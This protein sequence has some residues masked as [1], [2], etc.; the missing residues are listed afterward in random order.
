MR[1]Y[2]SLERAYKTLQLNLTNNESSTVSVVLF[3]A[4]TD[5]QITTSSATETSTVGVGST[6]SALAFNPSN[7]SVYVANTGDD[8]VSVIDADGNVTTI[9][10]GIGDAPRGVAFNSNDGNIWVSFGTDNEV[11]VIDSATN[12]V[13][14]TISVGTSPFELVYSPANQSMYVSINGDDEVAI[15][16]SSD[17]VT[18]VNVGDQPRGIAYNTANQEVY[19][20]NQADNNVTRID[21]DGNTT[22]I[23]VGTTPQGIAYNEINR[24]MYVANTLFTVNLI[25][26][27][28]LDDS[29]TTITS[30]GLQPTGVAYSKSNT[31]IYVTNNGSADVTVIDIADNIIQTV[32]VGNNPDAATYNSNDESIYVA[33]IVDSTVSIL[34]SSVTVE[35]SLGGTGLDYSN[36]IEQIR[37]CPLYVKGAK[38]LPSSDAQFN[39]DINWHWCD[40]SGKNIE[41]S[42]TPRQYFSADHKNSIVDLEALGNKILDGRVSLEFDMLANTSMNFIFYVND[43][44]L[45]DVIDML[46]P[47]T[48]L[49]EPKKI[50]TVIDIP[51]IEPISPIPFELVPTEIGLEDLVPKEIGTISKAVCVMEDN[52]DIEYLEDK[53]EELKQEEAPVC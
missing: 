35:A 23:S 10:S 50:K 3:G 21:T 36:V 52:S 30:S 25:T 51:T 29:T 31:N 27:I 42:F 34:G 1:Y 53:L 41:Q 24:N 6:P 18:T 48:E 17:T 5:E 16:D 46:Q 26:V 32:D 14:R 20:V 4:Y 39:E 19:V 12:T 44:C 45:G 13:L 8:T 37:S 47:P 43:Y 7:N 11:G 2:A 9:S 49:P 38:L 33:N 15:I 22:N 28:A 40:M